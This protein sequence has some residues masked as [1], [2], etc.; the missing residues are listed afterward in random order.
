MNYITLDYDAAHK[1]VDNNRFLEWDGWTIQ[2][3]RPNPRGYS[4]V[5]G[6]F[7]NG[8]WGILYRYP[9]RNDGNWRIPSTY[10]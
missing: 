9:V 1:A 10:V 3:W 2:T 5:R 8:R 7:R 4:D 6:S